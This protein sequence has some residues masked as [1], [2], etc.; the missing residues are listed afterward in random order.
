M[1]WRDEGIDR[2]DLA[3]AGG[4]G[5]GAF[6]LYAATACRT[7]FTG[8]SA[9]LAGAAAGFGV[10]HPPGYPLYTLLTALWVHLFPLAQRAFAAN[11]ASSIHGALAV[12]LTFLLARRLGA[13]RTGAGVAAMALALGRTLWGQSIAAEV[14]A[15]DL[16]LLTGAAH[17]AWSTGRS[18]SGRAWF[19]VG[20]M[21]GLWLGHRFINLAYLPALIL[22]TFAAHRASSAGARSRARLAPPL[23]TLAGGLVLSALPFLYLPL[24]SAA[25]PAIDIGDP[26]TLDRFWTVVRGAPYL[27]H[28]AGTTPELALARIGS[29]LTALPVESGPAIL[30]AVVGAGASLRRRGGARLLGVALLLLLATNQ[31]LSS[32]Y[33][34]RDIRVY[35]L[36]SLLA[37]A[38]L[39]A[40]G[41][42]ALRRALPERRRTL[43]GILLLALSA[44]GLAANFRVNDARTARAAHQRAADLLDS[45]APDAL[46][47]VE[48]D[49][50]THSVWYLQAIENRAPGVLVVSLGQMSDWY[51]DQLRARHPRDPIPDVV[52]GTPPAA[53]CLRLLETVGRERPVCFAF[54]PGELMRLT[55]GPWWG[56]RTIVPVGLALE[57]RPKDPPPDR[58][59]IAVADV[60]FWRDPRRRVPHLAPESDFETRMIG[61]EYALALQR[62]AEF[63][64]RR[65]RT[66]DAAE[67]YRAVLALRP[68]RWEQ[69]LTAAY[70]TIG[71]RV[72]VPDLESRARQALRDLP[73]GAPVP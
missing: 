13:S 32:L 73:G 58:D 46:L 72:P 6:A 25:N 60:A 11:F 7:I 55:A 3:A 53:F 23:G 26:Q 10:P 12:A 4:V 22:L 28:L 70:R 33:N 2:R 18:G 39:G 1:A 5:L 62:T 21:G 59:A 49:T 31:V 65:G 34:I 56:Q 67:L 35:H 20:L 42:D 66:E 37:L 43:A 44:T 41:A 61:L 48:G 63:L 16:L 30:L 50:E 54:D 27:R 29:F 17:A 40:L 36:P 68:A 19:V 71:R 51:Y 64:H 69:D 8:D 47:L 14:Y 45:I 15:F 57:A 24:A 38:L 9:E 52:R